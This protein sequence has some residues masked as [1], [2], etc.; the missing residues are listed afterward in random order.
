VVKLP[1]LL[2][3]EQRLIR[4]SLDGLCALL[5]VPFDTASRSSRCRRRRCCCA[6]IA[7]AAAK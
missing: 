7:S 2:A 5:G 1:V 3:V 6:G 4:T